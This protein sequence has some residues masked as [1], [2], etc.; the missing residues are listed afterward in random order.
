LPD[1]LKSLVM[2]CI[3]SGHFFRN[4][5]YFG[6][7]AKLRAEG[8][9]LKVQTIPASEWRAVEDAA[10]K[11]WD[12]VAE[13]GETAAKV[14]QIFKDYDAVRQKAGGLYTCG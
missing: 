9:K 11:F 5:W 4:Q 13:T 7:E 8:T 6:G 12:E 10:S 1:H 3:E 2:A 14:V